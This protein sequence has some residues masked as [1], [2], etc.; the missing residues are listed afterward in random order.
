[1]EQYYSDP[2]S[3]SDANS[4]LAE[5]D[6]GLRSNNN[7]GE[8]SEAIVRFPRLFQKYPFPILIN[9][10]L[11]K[12]ADV[13]RGG[14]NFIKL[15]VLRVCQRSERHLDKITNVD[16]FVKRIFSVTHSNDPVARAL[17]L[18]VLGAVSSVVLVSE[19]HA[20][21]QHHIRNVLNED[22]G[23]L[24]ELYG[25][26]YAAGRFA[27]RSKTFALNLCSKISEMVKGNLTPLEIKLRLIPI[28]RHMYHDA[29][30]ASYVR[31]TC[32]TLLLE[33]YP[34]LDFVLVTLRT[35]TRLSARTL[36]DVP[37]HIM[38][39]LRYL[40]QDSR[41]KVKE[42]V[43]KDLK[44]LASEDRSHLWTD[45]NVESLI[46]FA[47]NEHKQSINVSV[48]VFTV[49][50]ELISH[51][52]LDKF[53][54]SEGEESL[55]ME[56]CQNFCYQKDVSVA[57]AA[58]SLLTCIAVHRTE[59]CS[60]AMLAIESLFLLLTGSD[61]N[62]ECFSVLKDTLD[63]VVK[64]CDIN[65][66]A[67]EQF[68]DIFGSEAFNNSQKISVRLMLAQV[69]AS[70]GN[71]H[72]GVLRILLPD[73]YLCLEEKIENNKFTSIICTL[74]LQTLKGFNWPPEAISAWNYAISNVD[75]WT[76]YKIG[77]AATRYAQPGPAKDIFY[78]L[79]DKVSSENHYYWLTGIWHLAEAEEYLSDINNMDIIDR[80]NKANFKIHESI[81]SL[82]A[83]ASPKQGSMVF[84]IS[85]L[86]C[87]S[88]ALLVLA[89]LMYAC[90]SIRTSPPPAIANA[91][92]KQSHDDLQRCGRI[93]Y[94]L[95]KCVKEFTRVSSL[96]GKLYESCF[97]ADPSTLSQLSI[98]RQIYLNISRWIERVCLKS[99]RQGS[100][101]LEREINFDVEED[102]A[103]INV[104]QLIDIGKELA[105]KFN[106]LA[107]D[108]EAN[109]ISE[110]H[111]SV[112]VFIVNK[113]TSSPL[114]LPRSFY[115][116]RQVT[117]LSLAV[118]PSPRSPG[119]PISVS[120]SQYLSIKVEGVVSQIG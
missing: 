107:N 93:A 81:T 98:F 56:L 68:V 30:T 89:E 27:A 91:Q 83:A 116:S 26:I 100:M 113:L 109:P 60:E 8:Q 57:A 86:R 77:R 120:T 40:T 25:A 49:L 16:E 58:T 63:C 22:C 31:E 112:L 74:L 75:F 87:R 51:G 3:T 29:K 82:K 13:Y 18:R 15:C 96:Y 10:A 54:F 99:N 5:L 35:L 32:T 14:S 106:N 76:Q 85:Y 102:D 45:S 72:M 104:T 43:L 79:M 62:D 78:R 84:Q 66:E 55:V 17:T 114:F 80:L 50:R 111:T 118:T 110:K 33:S 1:M 44:F 47:L 42:T 24:V 4:A 23:D 36:I 88:E 38:L 39:L 61:F 70:L 92:A 117:S 65:P 115:Q 73:M 64:L 7:L 2:S 103:D 9:S 20:L 119:D 53:G 21:V 48:G 94:L 11:L 52:H 71:K 105:I 69:L 90:N 28:L 41:S 59:S 46:K 67:C 6:Q 19:R 34:S 37:D 12:L 95:R 97:D 108:P 101:F